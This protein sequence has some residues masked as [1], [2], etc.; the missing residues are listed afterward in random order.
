MPHTQTFA[1]CTLVAYSPLTTFLTFSCRCTQDTYA[2]A[3]EGAQG[4]YS[5]AKDA[6]ARAME[7]AEG[8]YADA[9]EASARAYTEAGPAANP[10]M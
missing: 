6:T 10:C 4:A 8:A 2:D 9:K 7:R 1:G 3:K 5:D